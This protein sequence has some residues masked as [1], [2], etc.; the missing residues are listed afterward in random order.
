MV[1]KRK[2]FL[3]LLPLLFFL[4]ATAVPSQVIRVGIYQNP[5]L[6]FVDEEGNPQGFVVDLLEEA[7]QNQNWAL[8]F[9]FCE[10]D[11][12]LRA[13]EAGEIDLLGPIAYSEERVKRFDFSEETLITNWGQVYVQR[14]E[15]DV[16]ILDL[17][18]KTLVAIEND[19]H[20]KSLKERLLRFGF[21]VKFIFVDDYDAVMQKVENNQAFGGII[22]HL[23]ALQYAKN[24]DVEQSAIIFNP[25]E[26]RFA[27]TKGEHDELLTAL[28]EEISIM[29]SDKSSIYYR[30]LNL[31]FDTQVET[32]MPLWAKWISAFLVFSL[33][34]LIFGGVFLRILVQKRTAAL[35]ESEKKYRNLVDNALVGVYITQNHIIRFANQGLADLFGYASAKEMIGLHVREMVAPVSWDTVDK[36]VRLKESGQKK[37]SHY[38]FKGLRKDG[39]TI[40]LEVLGAVIEYQGKPAVQGILIDITERI[41]AEERFEHLSKAALE[42]IIISEKGIILEANNTAEELFGYSVEEAI[43]MSTTEMVALEDRDLVIHHVLSGY[44]KPYIVTALRKDGS[45]FPAEINGRMM[46]YEGRVVRVTSIR[47][48]SERA[49]AEETLRKRTKEL[50]LLYQFSQELRQTLD[51]DLI[52]KHFYTFVSKIM[53]CDLMMVSSFAPKEK[54]ITC[55]YLIMDGKKQDIS[56]FPPLALNPDGKGTQSMV[57][58]TGKSMLIPDYLAQLETAKKT[59]YIDSNGTLDTPENRPEKEKVTRSAIVAPM[60]FSGKVIG[61][62]QVMS[63]KLDAYNQEDLRIMEALSSHIAITSNNARLHHEVQQHAQQLEMLNTITGTLATSLNLAD[64]LEI[65]LEEAARIIKFDSAA[66]F[67]AEKNGYVTIAKAVGDAAKFTG[68]SLPLKETLMQGINN[69]QPLILDEAT[70]SPYY[71][72]WNT[73]PTIRGW[74]GLPLIARDLVL[75]Y[76]TFDSHEPRAFSP[77]DAAL[78]ESFSPQIA[79]ALYNARL[80]EEIIQKTSEIEEYVQEGKKL[81]LAALNETIQTLRKELEEARQAPVAGDSPHPPL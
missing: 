71:K 5:P 73:D 34:A 78:A 36:E 16:S 40:D 57:I 11:E 52:Y 66:I 30:R 49:E 7:A 58:T 74:M 70:K 63:Y 39:A 22:N 60:L 41:R 18:G 6:S 50:E 2:H 68:I 77:Q 25:I 44:D 14:G 4:Q 27:A 29:K 20:T 48:I 23:Y 81:N 17:E 75:G 54:L 47:D 79:Q 61:V 26:V 65:I 69:Q 38:R 43:G 53:D 15:T 3:F 67:L 59:Y 1:F 28:D 42:A 55:D 32:T 45:T 72:K 21:S 80:L 12:C 56:E 19:I 31:W 9:I 35:Q 76:L 37:A 62:V 10:W 13:L 24:Y 33:I 8:D 51:L 64:L 46:R